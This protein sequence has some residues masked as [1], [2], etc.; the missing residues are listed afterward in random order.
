MRLGAVGAAAAKPARA[1]EHAR[2]TRRLEIKAL[3]FPRRRSK[4]MSTGVKKGVQWGWRARG[5][6]RL[7][8]GRVRRAATTYSVTTKKRFGGGDV[9]S[10]AGRGGSTRDATHLSPRAVHGQHS[11]SSVCH[12]LGCGLSIRACLVRRAGVV[13]IRR[14]DCDR[15]VVAHRYF[16]AFR[17]ESTRRDPA[18]ARVAETVES[19]SSRTSS[20]GARSRRKRL[21]DK[22]RNR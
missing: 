5:Q 6:R 4:E 16:R 19:A 21:N 15:M 14:D 22:Y 7:L 2:R 18:R 20:Q 1:A 8:G 3:L 10:R 12:H 17:D 13:W 11:D 9:S